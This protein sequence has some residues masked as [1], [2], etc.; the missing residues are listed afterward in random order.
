MREVAEII[1]SFPD[2]LPCV[3]MSA[4]GKTTNLLL[5]AGAQSIAK[6]TENIPSLKALRSIKELHRDTCSALD[7][8]A[9]TVGVVERLLTELQQLLTGL[10][11]MQ[12]RTIASATVACSVEHAGAC[13]RTLHVTALF[14][15]TCM[16]RAD[17][18]HC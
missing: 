6:G 10:S 1:A 3:V 16:P 4:M 18:M 7:L 9:E 5:E 13:I 8:D 11:I 12:A 14:Q 17:A 15:A 2:Q